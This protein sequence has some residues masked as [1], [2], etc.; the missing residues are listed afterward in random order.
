MWGNCVS[1]LVCNT[2]LSVFISLLNNLV[3][4]ESDNCITLTVFLLLCG[5]YRS[6]PRVGMRSVSKAFPNVS[7]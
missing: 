7:C 5:W 4:D 2:E 3:E 1:S 6:F